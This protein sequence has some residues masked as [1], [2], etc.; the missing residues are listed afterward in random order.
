MQRRFC[1]SAEIKKT[2]ETFIEE[3]YQMFEEYYSLLPVIR[4]KEECDKVWAE[5]DAEFKRMV[6]EIKK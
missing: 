5:V 4:P 3:Q 1:S 6:D 2:A